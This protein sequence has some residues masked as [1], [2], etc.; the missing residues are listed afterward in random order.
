MEIKDDSIA[1]SHINLKMNIINGEYY[2]IRKIG[3]IKY[4]YQ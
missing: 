2:K 3:Y 4:T 1:L